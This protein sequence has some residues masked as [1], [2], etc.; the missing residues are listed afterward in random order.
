MSCRGPSLHLTDAEPHTQVLA[1]TVL[2]SAV[3]STTLS[4]TAWAL[5]QHLHAPA[6][7]FAQSVLLHSCSF[8]TLQPALATSLWRVRGRSTSR[9]VSG[10]Q[11]YTPLFP[12]KPAAIA[13]VAATNSMSPRPRS[14]HLFCRFNQVL[15]GCQGTQRTAGHCFQRGLFGGL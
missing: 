1:A 14:L 7:L 2:A 3:H 15:S 12:N 11:I 9:A 8:Q 6:W 10:A 5:R 4:R 13:V